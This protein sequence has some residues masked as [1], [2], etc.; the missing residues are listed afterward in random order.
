MTGL[1]WY[2]ADMTSIDRH[3]AGVAL[4]RLNGLLAHPTTTTMLEIIKGQT[5][6]SIYPTDMIDFILN[7]YFIP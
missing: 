1:N 6:K 5:A 4:D 3:D 2:L 7:T